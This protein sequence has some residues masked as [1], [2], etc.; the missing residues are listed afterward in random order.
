MSQEI[1]AIT[2]VPDSKAS[3]G[4]HRGDIGQPLKPHSDAWML[5]CPG[6][7]Y[8]SNVGLGRIVKNEDGT[9]SSTQP[10]HCHGAK[11]RQR[12]SIERNEV[13]WL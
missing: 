4:Y 6:C 12:Y 3:L 13:R 11:M 8:L 7:G 5:C 2:V 1:T 10:L 9:V